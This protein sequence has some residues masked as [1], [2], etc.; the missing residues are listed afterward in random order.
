MLVLSL[1]CN[2][3]T[4]S[5]IETS[6]WNLN[7]HTGYSLGPIACDQWIS[8]NLCLPLRNKGANN[9]PKV[10]KHSGQLL[11]HTKEKAKA[12]TSRPE[13]HQ[14]KSDATYCVLLAS[15]TVVGVQYSN[16]YTWKTF[17]SWIN[18]LNSR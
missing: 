10:N 8:T 9:A 5:Y 16:F 12:K 17:T 3:E 18:F 11:A 14:N 15:T 4:N 13:T 6:G 1:F 2:S 7:Y